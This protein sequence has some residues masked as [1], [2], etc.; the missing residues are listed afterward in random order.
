[1]LVGHV[2]VRIGIGPLSYPGEGSTILQDRIKE[3][4]ISSIRVPSFKATRHHS[5]PSLFAA[6]L[7]CSILLVIGKIQWSDAYHVTMIP[8]DQDLPGAKKFMDVCTINSPFLLTVGVPF[9]TAHLTLA[10]WDS[11]VPSA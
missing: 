9:D 5:S 7:G 11:V 4:K 1:M 3:N 6:S 2:C 10:K 8:V